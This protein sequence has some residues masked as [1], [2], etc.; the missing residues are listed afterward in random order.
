M[1]VDALVAFADQALAG[2]DHRGSTSSRPV[3][4]RGLGG[5]FEARG[6]STHRPVWML[7][8]RSRPCQA[9]RIAVEDV[10]SDAVNSLRT[11]WFAED[12][13]DWQF[14]DHLAEGREVA[15]ILGMPSR[16]RQTRWSRGGRRCAPTWTPA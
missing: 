5:E 15:G 11:A 12:F 7:H 2:L 14:G 10:P 3:S 9:R 16:T 8:D 13:P 4:R 1:S 6:W